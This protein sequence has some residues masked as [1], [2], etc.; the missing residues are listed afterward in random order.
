MGTSFAIPVARWS[1]WPPHGGSPGAAPDVSFVQPALRRRLGP[2]ARM[3][4]H[5]ANDC[6]REVRRARLVFASRHGELTYAVQMLRALASGEPLSPTLFS[7]AVHNAAAGL[8]SMIRADRSASTA[9]AA[10]RETLGHALLEAYCQHAEDE[11]SPVLAVFADAPLPGEYAAFRDPG[12]VDPERGCAIAVLLHTPCDRRVTVELGQ[13]GD[14][15][16]TR[17]ESFRRALA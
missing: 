7:L 14:E 13:G 16:G 1:V 5:V 10:G 12:D 8:Y 11:S 15:P 4:L 17:T 3:M 6:L 9:L 2:L